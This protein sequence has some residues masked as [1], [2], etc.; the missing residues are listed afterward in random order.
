MI[1]KRRQ[2]QRPGRCESGGFTLLEIILALAIL[3]G[4]IATLGEIMRLANLNASSARDET[5]A[6]LLASSVMDELL[7]GARVVG[8]VTKQQFDYPTEL[9]WV[10]S[11]MTESTNYQEVLRVGVRVELAIDSKLE[12]PHFE[13]YRW[14]LDP[15]YVTTLTEYE[16]QIAAEAAAQAEASAAASGGGL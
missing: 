14:I 1:A 4:S 11:V 3:A 7:S 13:M 9:P 10:F 8:P 5:A 6:E 2:T 15:Q 16:A 12:P